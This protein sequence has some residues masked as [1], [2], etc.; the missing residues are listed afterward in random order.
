MNWLEAMHQYDL[1]GRAH[2]LV[3]VVTVQGSAPRPAGTKMV[4]A[5]DALVGSVGGGALEHQLVSDARKLLS[6]GAE[7]KQGAE[8]GP[9]AIEKI[10]L[11]EINLAK[12]AA[13][14]CG[15]VV[16]VLL[17]YMPASLPQIVIFGAGHVAQALVAILAELRLRLDVVDSRANML[18]GVDQLVAKSTTR[19]ATINTR[20]AA[21]P[22]LL[23]ADPDY[24]YNAE[25]LYLVI[26]HSHDLDFAVCEAVL[27]SDGLPWCGLI[28]SESKAAA[29]RSRLS[30]KG[31]STEEIDRLVAPVGLH[32]LHGKE[33]MAV[34]VSI[35]A[36]LLAM[37]Q[38]SI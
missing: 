31:F 5:S 10:Q 12:D 33:P 25:T 22:E 14:C 24:G 37:P 35:A 2:V 11:R 6:E 8:A 7:L 9:A 3:T 27:S 1:Q 16:T 23:V 4:V 15:G 36:Q 32:Q 20:L 38:L 28:A 21:A 13:Q 34:A 29:F 17:E 26:T 30:K 19:A 18:V